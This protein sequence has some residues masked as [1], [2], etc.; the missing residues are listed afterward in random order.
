M[1]DFLLIFSNVFFTVI[2]HLMLKHGMTKVGRINS[3][4]ALPAT[5][6]RALGNPF[7]LF[8]LAVFVGTS[9]LWLVVLSRIKLSLAYPMLSMSYVLAIIL[10]WLLLK[11]HIPWIRIL[12]AFVIISGVCLVSITTFN[13]T[14][15]VTDAYGKPA[16]GVKVTV[17][18]ATK[19]RN[20]STVT[21]EYGKYQLA[22]FDFLGSG[23][24]QG[25][26]IEVSVEENGNH[27]APIK[28]LI[29]EE[30]VNRSSIEVGIKLP[31]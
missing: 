25:D 14:G 22:F 21:D 11:E 3:I 1:K 19:G 9:M 30:E 23:T 2:G 6:Y 27:L 10:A 31:E 4:S 13:V 12:G 8:G 18:N 15:A 16:A 26:E 20:D 7:V 29:T 17:K 24:T 5:I 28:H